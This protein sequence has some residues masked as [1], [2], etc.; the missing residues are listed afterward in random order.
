M[1]LKKVL[2]R[3]KFFELWNCLYLTSQHLK[4]Q[5]CLEITKNGLE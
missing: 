5:H 2:V 1:E 3:V 4:K